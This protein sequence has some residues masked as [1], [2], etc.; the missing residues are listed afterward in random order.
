MPRFP[1]WFVP[2]SRVLLLALLA[3]GACSSAGASKAGDA[4]VST[5]PLRV[6]F[7]DW[8]SG[9]KLTLVDQSHT[10]RSKLYSSARSLDE[11]GTKVTTDEVLE[12]TLKFFKDQGF[13][14]HARAGAAAGG[15]DTAQSLEVETPD[16]TV[17][18]DLGRTT[19][20]GDQRIFRTCRDNF[21]ALYNNVYQLQSVD[22]APDWDAQQKKLQHKSGD[23][24]KGG[25]A[26]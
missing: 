1:D 8:R 14:E 16:A 15:G 4:P 25:G 12:E 19:T 13:F 11:A 2:V 18:M 9:Q 20:A 26:P 5:R 23:S 6:H 22:Q 24:T 3:L 17:H 21:A 7:V 10:D